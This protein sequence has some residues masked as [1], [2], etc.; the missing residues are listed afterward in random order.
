MPNPIFRGVSPAAP[1]DGPRINVVAPR[2]GA[3]LDF[4]ILSLDILGVPT[5]YDHDDT[6]GKPRSWLCDGNGVGCDRCGIVKVQ[7]L[8]FVGAWD[9]SDLCRIVVRLGPEGALALA[10]VAERA[11]AVRGLRVEMTDA[12]TRAGRQILCYPSRKHPVIP[13]PSPF[14]IEGIVARL[15]RVAA[16]PGWL[17]MRD[18]QGGAS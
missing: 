17:T 13:L 5:H 4:T 6:L 9:H 14:P 3:V 1:N 12:I 2:R 15:L 16:L 18:M 7:P 10:G 8:C 11:G